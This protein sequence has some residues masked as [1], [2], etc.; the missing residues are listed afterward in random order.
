MGTGKRW[1]TLFP[2]IQIRMIS[3]PEK[4]M[5]SMPLRMYFGTDC[6]LTRTLLCHCGNA[7]VA[8][9]P[10]F[11]RM[12]EDCFSNASSL[13]L[14]HKVKSQQYDF[15]T[16]DFIFFLG[17]LHKSSWSNDIPTIDRLIHRGFEISIVVFESGRLHRFAKNFVLKIQIRCNGSSRITRLVVNVERL[18]C[19]PKG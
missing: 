18:R 12:T 10:N 19:L 2:D 1:G 9:L 7:V 13:P 15:P 11:D 17:W 6:Q 16:I 14:P 5:P 8:L 4:L 3:I